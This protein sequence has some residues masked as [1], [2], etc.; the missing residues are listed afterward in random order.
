MCKGWVRVSEDSVANTRREVGFWIEV[1]EYNE[2][3]SNVVRRPVS[4]AGDGDYTKKALEE[5][6]VEHGVP[7]RLLHPWAELKDFR[8]PMSKDRAKK[9]AVASSASSATFANKEVLVRLM[10]SEYATQTES[11]PTMKREDGAA[12]L[13]IKMMKMEITQKKIELSKNSNKGRSK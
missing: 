4:G 3:N 7:F 9:K 11:F 6:R 13:E 2:D 12:F 10:I 5:Y 1:L 8:R